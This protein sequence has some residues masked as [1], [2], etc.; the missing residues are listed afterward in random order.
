MQLSRITVKNF[1]NFSELDVSLSGNAIV[2]GENRVGKSNLL[3]ALRLLL[4][5]AL[6]ESARQLALSDFWD[7]LGGP[8]PVT[9]S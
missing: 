8:R 3:Y 7:G 6:P 2:V 9:R 4:D 5:P 1:R